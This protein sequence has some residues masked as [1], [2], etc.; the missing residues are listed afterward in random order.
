MV[1]LMN[2]N[3]H[4]V[5]IL[6]D[7]RV[8][9]GINHMLIINFYENLWIFCSYYK[10]NP[11]KIIELTQLTIHFINAM[12]DLPILFLGMQENDE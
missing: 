5:R 10:L 4:A 12:V 3:N 7:E 8:F 1:I 11:C 6:P 2:G 9:V